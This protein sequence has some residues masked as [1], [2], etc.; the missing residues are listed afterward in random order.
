MTLRY[1]KGR[2]EVTYDPS[3]TT[4]EQI[5]NAI[6]QN[7]GFKAEIEQPAKK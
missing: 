5:A 7:S 1:E 2:A 3:K 6:T 4:P